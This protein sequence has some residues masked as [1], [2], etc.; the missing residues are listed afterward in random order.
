MV[1]GAVA[2][3]LVASM[4]TGAGQT[5]GAT[6]GAVKVLGGATEATGGATTAGPGVTYLV[7]KKS[8]NLWISASASVSKS[9]KCSRISFKKFMIYP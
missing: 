8:I 5:A 7:S 4:V 1:V 2:D 9:F 6:M 3:A